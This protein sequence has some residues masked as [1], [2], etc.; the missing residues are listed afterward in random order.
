MLLIKELKLTFALVFALLFGQS[1]TV[2]TMLFLTKQELLIF[3]QV[4][5]KAI[6]WINLWSLL[7]SL[8]QRALMDDGCWMHSVD[9]GRSHYLQPG[10][11][12]AGVMLEG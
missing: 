6:Y 3:L 9:G 12:V 5:H 8:E 4:V 7:L 1:R 2:E 11:L 10:W